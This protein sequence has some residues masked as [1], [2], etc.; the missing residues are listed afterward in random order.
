MQSDSPSI[1]I[2]VDSSFRLGY[3]SKLMTIMQNYIDQTLVLLIDP[4]FQAPDL[5]RTFTTKNLHIQ[6]F[7]LDPNLEMHDFTRLLT[8]LKPKQ[9]MLEEKTL[10]YLNL[11]KFPGLR[12]SSIIVYKEE[13]SIDFKFQNPI[14]QLTSVNGIID[15]KHI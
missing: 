8:K 13:T 3:A 9:L 2:T 10:Q 11:L 1:Y 4:L 12:N 7:P 15:V 14:R 6:Q 5:L